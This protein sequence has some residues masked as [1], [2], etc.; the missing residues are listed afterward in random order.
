MQED[1]VANPTPH[2]EEAGMLC[3]QIRL[4]PLPHL[5]HGAAEQAVADRLGGAMATVLLLLGAGTARLQPVL[6]TMRGQGALCMM[7][8]AVGCLPAHHM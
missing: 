4:Q 3:H 7:M 2:L 5:L 8:Q 1:A 6:S